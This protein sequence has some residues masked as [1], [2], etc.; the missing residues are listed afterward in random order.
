MTGIARSTTALVVAVVVLLGCSGDSDE[1]DSDKRRPAQ[2]PASRPL[3]PT[4]VDAPGY[5]A[6]EDALRAQNLAVCDRRAEAGDASGSYERRFFAVAVGACPPE[7]ALASAPA[8]GVVV[9][10]YDSAAIRDAG[11]EV[12]FGDRQVAWTYQQFVVSVSDGSRP[13]VAEGVEAAMTSLGAHKTY[14]ERAGG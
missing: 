6:I 2:P 12:D 5:G 7:S 8:G 10:A 3:A 4:T 11:A 1:A 13:E 14:D 9:S